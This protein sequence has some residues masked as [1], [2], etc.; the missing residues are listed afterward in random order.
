MHR[1]R[2]ELTLLRQSSVWQHVDRPAR[3]AFGEIFDAA[4][5][6]RDLRASSYSDSRHL[7]ASALAMLNSAL[8][9]QLYGPEA[10]ERRCAYFTKG[11]CKL[12]EKVV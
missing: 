8:L 12:F 1:C 4:Y 9:R 3:R 5:L 11:R 7:K 2:Q 10:G 6:T